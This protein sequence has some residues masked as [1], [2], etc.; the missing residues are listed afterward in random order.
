MP[1]PIGRTAWTLAPH[2]IAGLG[3]ADDPIPILPPAGYQV[4]AAAIFTAR[5]KPAMKVI[6]DWELIAYFLRAPDLVFAP[7]D[8][9][10][11]RERWAAFVKVRQAVRLAAKDGDARR[12]LRLLN[13]LRYRWRQLVERS[14][15]LRYMGG[16]VVSWP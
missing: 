16:G 10:W 3:S 15:G 12:F 7:T 11:Y 8:S 5:T 9:H 4:G 13:V 1:T 14:T 6:P 2:H